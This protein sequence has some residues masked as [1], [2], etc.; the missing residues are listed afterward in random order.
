MTHSKA[1]LKLV[2]TGSAKLR[3]LIN[4]RDVLN[5]QIEIQRANLDGLQT[6]LRA[7]ESVEKRMLGGDGERRMRL[8]GQKRYIY[9]L[10]A[11]GALDLETISHLLPEHGFNPRYSRAIVRRALDDGDMDG[12]L[13]GEFKL[14]AA[15]HELLEKAPLPADWDKYADAFD[16]A[17]EY[18]NS[19]N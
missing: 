5:H 14:T 16:A 10:V 9:Q 18:F 6:A 15:G 3:E 4:E 2:E 12:N 8:G 1:L 17:R 11:N 19:R 13:E 7:V